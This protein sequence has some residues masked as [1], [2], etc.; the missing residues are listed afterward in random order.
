MCVTFHRV[1][2]C[3][4]SFTLL[5][6][7]LPPISLCSMFITTFPRF[8][9]FT[10]LKLVGCL[11]SLVSLGLLCFF[12]RFA[13]FLRKAGM[14]KEKW[15]AVQSIIPPASYSTQIM[16]QRS[17]IHSLYFQPINSPNKNCS[18]KSDQKEEHLKQHYSHENLEKIP[19]CKK[20]L[21]LRPILAF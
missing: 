7:G 6:G 16:S 4:A 5:G 19:T 18:L 2:V 1:S 8:T 12:P 13:L 15:A 21:N 3:E 14:L 17:S 11:C 20:C 9:G 10:S